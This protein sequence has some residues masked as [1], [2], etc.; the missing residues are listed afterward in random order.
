MGPLGNLVTN[1]FALFRRTLLRYV[2]SVRLHVVRLSSVTFL[3]PAQM[4][5]LFVNIF[6]SFTILVLLIFLV[7]IVVFEV[8]ETLD[9]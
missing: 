9:K 6:A 1:I 2:K 7:L 8:A 5:E 3:R 4:V